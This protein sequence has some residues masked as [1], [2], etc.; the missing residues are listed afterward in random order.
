M[1]ERRD[2]VAEERLPVTLS[3]AAG[4]SRGHSDARRPSPHAH[5]FIAVTVALIIIA[6]AAVVVAIVVAAGNGRPSTGPAWSS[7]T[8]PDSGLAGEREIAAAVSP[9]YEAAPS[10]QLA[11][12][13]VRNI[14]TSTSSTSNNP[15][16]QIAVRNPANGSLST[17][18]G[19]SALYDLCGLGTSCAI[20]AGTPSLARELLLRREALEL[21][22]YTFK[23]ISGI[24]TVVAVLPPGHATVTA[25]L[26][27]TPTTRSAPSTTVDI[28]VVFQ[29]AG[30]QRELA[31]PLRDTLPEQLPPTVAQMPAAPEAALVRVITGQTLFTQ[32]TVQAQDGSN[33][34]VLDPL[35]PQ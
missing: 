24:D 11:V 26:T 18:G 5:K 16:T 23:Y 28:A 30:L 27:P 6:V 29:R 12:V 13:T 31:Q 35:P 1:S 2:S 25:N 20:A 4:S 33:V 21:A 17:V 3:H 10:V 15:G 7:W 19:T 8:P 14:T 22:L 32:R 9:F 34:L